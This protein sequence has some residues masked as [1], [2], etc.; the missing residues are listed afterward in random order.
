MKTA[1]QDTKS[2]PSTGSSAP[3]AYTVVTAR[4]IE[5]IEKTQELPWRRPWRKSRKAIVGKNKLGQKSY[6]GINAFMTALFTDLNGYDS[7]EWLTFNQAK[8]LGG[9]IKQGEKG[10]PCFYFNFKEDKA[11]ESDK[12]EMIPIARY[13]TIFNLSQCEGIDYAALDL[14]DE[15][16]YD[17]APMEQAERLLA[18]FRDTPKITHTHDNRAFYNKLTDTINLPELKEFRERESYYAT[19]FHELTHATGHAKR[20]DRKSLMNSAAFGSHEYS[21]EEL[22]AEF[23]A[24]FLSSDCG[25]LQSVENNSAAYLQGWLSALKS[26]PRWLVDAANQ[27]QKAVNY[28]KDSSP[29]NPH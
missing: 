4:I 29:A 5:I 28:L 22:V 12:I 16:T 3:T 17:H 23:G 21:K 13:Y 9:H 26:N 19:L 24:C 14:T 1:T 2:F 7:N 8:A 11:N 25:I 27:A 10:L 20:L 18:S 15:T 6:S